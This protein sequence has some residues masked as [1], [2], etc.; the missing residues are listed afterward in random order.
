MA[1]KR[2]VDGTCV[3][4]RL[5]LTIAPA[6]SI[7]AVDVLMNH[8]RKVDVTNLH[9]RSGAWS[10]L[11]C[12]LLAIVVCLSVL[13]S[14]LAALAAGLVAGGTLGNLIS[15]Q[16]NN[17]WIPNPIVAAR[18]AFNVGDVFVLLGVPLL[19]VALARVAILNRE[20]IDRHIPPRR[21]ERALRRRLGL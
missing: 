3:R 4:L 7:A 19:V 20:H 16:Q 6:L 5:S 10:V 8:A 15:A 9:Q 14:R 18:V 17:G 21:W 13:P 12:V 11:S 1:A 2:S